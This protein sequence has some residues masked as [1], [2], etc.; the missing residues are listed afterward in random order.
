[1]E[2]NGVFAE[3]FAKIKNKNKIERVLND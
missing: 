3:K 1:M 2:K